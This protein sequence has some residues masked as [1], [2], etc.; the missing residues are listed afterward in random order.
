M[1]SIRQGCYTSQTI[2][3]ELQ[4]NTEENK[5]AVQTI[6]VV[7][8]QHHSLSINWSSSLETCETESI[9]LAA[10]PKIYPLDGQ[11]LSPKSQSNFNDVQFKSFP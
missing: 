8:V 6:R 2:L 10:V 5:N 9:T 11:N 7:T 3:C 1:Y 4:T